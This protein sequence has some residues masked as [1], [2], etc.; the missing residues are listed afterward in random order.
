MSILD[1]INRHQKQVF[2]RRSVRSSDPYKWPGLTF[3]GAGSLETGSV[4]VGS[5]KA[6]TRELKLNHLVFKG[7]VPS[8]YG[9]WLSFAVSPDG[10]LLATPF[11][12]N[13]VLVWRL[14]DGL[15]FSTCK[16]RAIQTR[17]IPS[18]SLPTV[19]PSSLGHAMLLRLFGMSEA[20][21]RFDG[22]KN[23]QM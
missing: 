4:L 18:H 6:E 23:I 22:S 19:A 3:E 16:S 8:S 14:S 15:W 21:V 2:A 5:T 1:T 12:S 13:A 10:K 17:F 11:T 7:I 9:Q 20:A